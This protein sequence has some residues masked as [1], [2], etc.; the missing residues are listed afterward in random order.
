MIS[1][2]V[3]RL[4]VN[5]KV[6]PMKVTPLIC[7]VLLFLLFITPPVAG[8]CDTTTTSPAEQT[9]KSE[10]TESD[11]SSITNPAKGALNRA[12]DSLRDAMQ[13]LGE[14]GKL[15]LDHQLPKLKA[16]T[17]GILQDTQKLL[18][19]WEDKIIKEIDKHRETLKPP[20]KPNKGETLPS[21]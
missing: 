20:P 1:N 15:T 11:P 8:F 9:N 21:I 5:E 18:N 4:D 19:R 16:Q 17:D 14:A 10:P 12:R 3:C 6:T 7:S 2:D 13:A